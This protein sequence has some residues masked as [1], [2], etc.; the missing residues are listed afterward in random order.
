MHPETSRRPCCPAS[1]H[2]RNR[3]ECCYHGGYHWQAQYVVCSEHLSDV[4][5]GSLPII[6]IPWWFVQ[7]DAQIAQRADVIPYCRIAILPSPAPIAS[8]PAHVTPRSTYPKLPDHELSDGRINGR[9]DTRKN[10]TRRKAQRSAAHLDPEH[11][12][13]EQ[14]PDL[15][16]TYSVSCTI[17][18]IYMVYNVSRASCAV[19][20]IHNTLGPIAPY[21]HVDPQKTP[22]AML[23]IVFPKRPQQCVR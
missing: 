6:R 22:G 16:R 9:T 3:H 17:Y 4:Q 5:F 8:C 10:N 14:P 1:R 23:T 15:W 21:I 2:P 13:P 11:I 12:E 19:Y 18:I 20:N 7:I